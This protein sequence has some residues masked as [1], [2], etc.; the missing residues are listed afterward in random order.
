MPGR[1]LS[2]LPMFQLLN[3]EIFK[4]VMSKSRRPA[5]RYAAES[6]LHLSNSEIAALEIAA[7]A[8]HLGL[9]VRVTGEVGLPSQESR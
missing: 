9:P 5:I 2:E 1:M 3:T 7:V 6:T 8:T 4:Q